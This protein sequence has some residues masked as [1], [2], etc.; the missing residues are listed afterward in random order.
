[1]K[2]QDGKFRAAKTS[3]RDGLAI[4]PRANHSNYRIALGSEAVQPAFADIRRFERARAAGQGRGS[5][6]GQEHFGS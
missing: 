6:S 3:Q 5:P 1:M 4:Q 2:L